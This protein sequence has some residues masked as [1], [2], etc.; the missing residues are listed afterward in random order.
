V[1]YCKDLDFEDLLDDYLFEEL[2]WLTNEFNYL[3]KGKEQKYSTIDAQVANHIIN[4]IS[5]INLISHN[6]RAGEL[7]SWTIEKIKMEYPELF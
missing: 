3:F 7:I 1:E 4:K 2:E 5:E 6:N